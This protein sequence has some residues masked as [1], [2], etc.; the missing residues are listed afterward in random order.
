[1]AKNERSIVS[2]LYILLAIALILSLINVFVLQSRFGKVKEAQE[3][4]KELMKPANI[5]LIKILADCKDCFDV[6]D[7]VKRIKSQNIN[8]TK[9]ETL[10]FD[11]PEAE[12]LIDEL[13]IT[14]LPTVVISGEINRTDKLTNF[15][16]SIGNV[17]DN[18]FVYTAISAPYYDVANKKVIGLVKVIDI[19]DSLCKDCTELNTVDSLKQN[20]VVISENR[21]V[22]FSSREGQELIK[23]FSIQQIPAVLISEDIDSYPV[24]KQALEEM[25]LENRNGFYAVHSIVPPYISLKENKLVGIVTLV[26]LNDKSCDECY[27]VNVNK[28]I[29][30]RFGI[31]VKPEDI[32]EIDIA[33]KEGKEYIKT[34]SINKVPIIILSPDAKY[35]NGLA[36]AWNNVGSVEKDGWFVMRNP[37]LLGAYKDLE[38]NKVVE[39][40]EVQNA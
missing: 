38:K 23:K 2:Y 27:D 32:Y 36:N 13:V 4:M 30:Q 6:E 37:E 33:S 40:E 20:G 1:M 28:I 7:A 25:G 29:L 35:Y 19:I 10:E 24:V 3:V 16:N 39:P 9:E 14:K 15:F 5:E 12:S 21:K 22:E 26:M 11:S 34:Y 17:M 8:I 18:K 31:N